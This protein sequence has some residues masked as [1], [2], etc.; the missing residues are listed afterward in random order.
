M[1]TT[2]SVNS[3]GDLNF[4]TGHQSPSPSS[5]VPLAVLFLEIYS[6]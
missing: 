3:S 1:Q 5:T 2:L 6:A 4:V